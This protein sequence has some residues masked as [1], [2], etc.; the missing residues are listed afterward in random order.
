[1]ELTAQ[2][3]TTTALSP[4][5]DHHVPSERDAVC[6]VESVL[7]PLKKGMKSYPCHESIPNSY[8]YNN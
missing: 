5:E 3:Y 6:A 7:A 4:A 2:R 1:M 8:H